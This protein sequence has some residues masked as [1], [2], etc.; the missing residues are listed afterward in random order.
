MNN[1]QIARILYTIADLLEMQGVTWKPQAYRRA[2]QNL[3]TFAGDLAEL[4]K[5]NQLTTIPGVGE[6]IGKKI[7]ELVKTGK[8]RY[9]EQ[10][11][12][13]MKVD[14]EA[15]K[16]IPFL[17]P[18][19]IKVLYDRL[20]VKTVRDL[21]RAIKQK[22]VRELPGFGEETEKN[23]WAG[24]QLRKKK[25]L[26]FSYQDITPV[27]KHIKTIFLALPFVKKVDIAGS[28][29]RKSHTVGDLDVLVV[30]EQPLDVMKA[31]TS[32]PNI[33]RVLAKGPTKGSILLRKGLQVDLRIVQ[34]REYGAALLYFTG[35]KDHNV[36]LRNIALRKGLTLNEYALTEL[37]TGKWVAG[38]TEEE[39]YGALGFRFIPPEERTNTGELVKFR[40]K[41]GN[42]RKKQGDKK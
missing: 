27:A 8:L 1:L 24:I 15:L 7:E 18:K 12:K 30:S 10:L 33:A 21:E 16:E 26:R 38:N 3:E 41:K 23:L 39:I 29:R 20:G 17:G 25:P 40:M 4:V 35:S 22:N 13:E 9:Y 36:A 14:I 2:A 28:F 34:P 6:Q 37:R 32:L 31:F 11:Q 42:K 5:T 19:R